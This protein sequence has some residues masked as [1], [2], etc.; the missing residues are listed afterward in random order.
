MRGAGRETVIFTFAEGRD[1][2]TGWGVPL[3]WSWLMDA[4]FCAI[5]IKETSAQ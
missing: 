3:E 4:D 1:R 2:I 5:G